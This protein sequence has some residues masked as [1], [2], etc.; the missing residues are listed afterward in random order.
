MTSY[1]GVDARDYHP[2]EILKNDVVI[3]PF[4][5]Y[6]CCKTLGVTF[7]LQNLTWH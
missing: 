2:N 3:S 5:M 7:D 1:R 4:L 6:I